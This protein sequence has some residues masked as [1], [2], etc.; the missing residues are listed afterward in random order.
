MLRPLRTVGQFK[1]IIARNSTLRLTKFSSNW[2]NF[3]FNYIIAPLMHNCQ[4]PDVVV[5]SFEW[6]CRWC[7]WPC[8]VC[9]LS[10]LLKV[11]HCLLTLEPRRLATSSILPMCVFSPSQYGSYSLAHVYIH[12][13]HHIDSHQVGNC[14]RNC[15][16]SFPIYPQ[17]L[18]L[19]QRGLNGLRLLEMSNIRE[20]QMC[21]IYEE[22]RKGSQRAY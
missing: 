9:S 14:T 12:T 20:F 17:R 5:R 8:C 15:E 7:K 13:H 2:D 19:C 10:P 16:L 11:V 18:R 22:G 1:W 4:E 6:C 21:M 3:S